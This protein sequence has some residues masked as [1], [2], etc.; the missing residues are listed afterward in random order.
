MY[1]SHFSIITVTSRYLNSYLNTIEFLWMKM[2][3]PILCNY[4][5]CYENNFHARKRAFSSSL[6]FINFVFQ[7]ISFRLTP[8]INV[9]YFISPPLVKGFSPSP[10]I[11]SK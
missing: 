3:F 2:C 8:G 6:H 10:L 11:Y 4:E 1:F 9:I 5:I 7:A